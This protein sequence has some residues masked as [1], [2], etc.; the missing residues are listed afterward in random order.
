MNQ[1]PTEVPTNNTNNNNQQIPAPTPPILNGNI[2]FNANR[3]NGNTAA[4]DVR[5]RLFHV[6]F[7][8]LSIM[9]ARSCSKSYRRIFEFLSLL[10]ALSS[11][12]ILSYLH[13]VFNRHPMNCLSEIQA[14][15]PR[16]GILRVEIVNNVTS[17]Y[18]IKQS[19]EK[20]YSN[21]LFSVDKILE[22]NNATNETAIYSKNSSTSCKN[23]DINEKFLNIID[24]YTINKTRTSIIDYFYNYSSFLSEEVTR[25]SRFRKIFSKNIEKIMNNEP[26][27]KVI[28][29]ALLEFE[30]ISKI[31]RNLVFLNSTFLILYFLFKSSNGRTLYNRVF[32]RIWISSFVS[33]NTSKTQYYRFISHS[34]FVCLFV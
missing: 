12:A 30:M 17:D 31:C 9:Y 29:D 6:L 8:R 16:D 18:G 20:E 4:V 5:D 13:I 11:L 34:R 32:F 15:W 22:Q 10:T 27:F 23:L 28:K 14:T 2:T 1:Q 7:Y 25:S 24:N 26:T 3:N 19:Y 33:T 21:D